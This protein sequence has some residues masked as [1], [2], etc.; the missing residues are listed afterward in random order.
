[1]PETFESGKRIVRRT[2]T[3]NIRGV[4]RGAV[5]YIKKKKHTAISW[6]AK[7][8]KQYFINHNQERYST[9]EQ[10]FGKNFIKCVTYKVWRIAFFLLTATAISDHSSPLGCWVRRGAI[11]FDKALSFLKELHHTY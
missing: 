2:H 8:M 11:V 3:H 5:T 10:Q 7:L 1:M 6:A 4:K 9:E